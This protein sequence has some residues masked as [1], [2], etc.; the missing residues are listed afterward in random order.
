MASSRSLTERSHSRRKRLFHP[1]HQQ[2][3]KEQTKKE[4]LF[5]HSKSSEKKHLEAGGF[6]DLQR[7]KT[8]APRCLVLICKKVMS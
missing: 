1:K 5:N 2:S 3:K 4:C 8:R 6:F 7:G